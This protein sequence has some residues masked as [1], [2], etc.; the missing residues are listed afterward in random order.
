MIF[1]LTT[2]NAITFLIYG[3]LCISTNHMVN[4][5]NRFGLAKFR[6]LTGYLEILGALGQ[7]IGFYF[8]PE[9]NAFSTLGL[10]TLMFMGVVIRIKI[11]DNWYEI[12]PALALLLLNS[13]LFY[14]GVQNLI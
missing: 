13:Y 8:S 2:I 11:K 9:I 6:R 10:A 1:F 12:M 5:F 14:Q 7:I 4:E 3:T